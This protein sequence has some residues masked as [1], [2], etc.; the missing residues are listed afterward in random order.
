M[1]DVISIRL[2]TEENTTVKVVGVD[3][4]NIRA[5]MFLRSALS[6]VS[7]RYKNFPNEYAD[8]Y[9]ATPGIYVLIS[10]DGKTIYIGKSN[11][12]SER[13]NTHFSSKDKTEFWTNTMVFV[14]DG[15][16]PLN[17]S[18][19]SHL[20][21]RL[22]ELA[23]TASNVDVE[24]DA[25]YELRNKQI[26]RQQNI[27]AN[28]RTA[29]NN[30][31]AV[32]LLITKALGLNYFDTAKKSIDESVVEAKQENREIFYLK[33]A[34]A[35]AMMIVDGDEYIVLKGSV[36]RGDYAPSFATHGGG[37]NLKKREL[38]EKNGQLVRDGNK[39]IV[40]DDISFTSPSAAG[41]VF[42]GHSINGRIEWKTKDKQTLK[43]IENKTMVSVGE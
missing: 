1:A 42:A 30:F 9:L 15:A 38:L 25:P 43:D 20:E 31:L 6:F 11:N 34:G 36:A 22:I 23:K 4:R 13:L 37:M 24:S 40:A 2:E 29:A 19:I 27:N 26:A 18:Q 12:V 3:G 14:S 33:N 21:Y 17:D 7:K 35:D 5:L 28:D 10:D 41:S 32:L 16:M 39:L 8:Y